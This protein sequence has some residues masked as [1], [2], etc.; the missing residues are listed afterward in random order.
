MN[1]E[2]RGE[3]GMGSATGEAL[4]PPAQPPGTPAGLKHVTGLMVFPIHAE[5]RPTP[6][7]HTADHFNFPNLCDE[8]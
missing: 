5:F 7:L 2:P 4:A 1:S 8:D 6:S 3:S